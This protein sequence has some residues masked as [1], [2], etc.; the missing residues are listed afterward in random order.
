MR[1][2]LTALDELFPLRLVSFAVA[3]LLFL[4]VAAPYA[5]ADDAGATP[6]APSW[7]TIVVSYA[8]P[9]LE[10]AAA[11]AVTWIIGQIIRLLGITDQAKRLQVEGQLRDALHFAAE[12]G[13][14]YAFAKLGVPPTLTASASV[15]ADAIAYVKDKNPDTVA[16]FG[17]DDAALEH[18]ILSKLP[19]LAQSTPLSLFSVGIAGSAAET[20]AAKAAPPSQPAPAPAV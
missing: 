13:L 5:F 20:D 4:W 9:L 19:S 15:I 17:L 2:F 7:L 3:A 16:A 1:K 14:K 11:A 10:A 18:I 6:A 8:M 12:N